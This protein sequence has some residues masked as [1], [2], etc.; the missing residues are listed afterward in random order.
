MSNVRIR[1]TDIDLDNPCDAAKALRG[2]RIQIAAGGQTEV[3][4]FGDDEVRYS[5]ANIAALDQEI[6][7]LS[8]ECD[9]ATG[10]TRRR[11]AKRMRFI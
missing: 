10:G 9:R 2:L 7:R 3:V 5:K 4:R 1:K 11:F 8:A 6:D